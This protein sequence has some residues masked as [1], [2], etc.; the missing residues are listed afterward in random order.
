MLLIL[1]QE[2][3]RF[4]IHKRVMELRKEPAVFAWG[5]GKFQKREDS[6]VGL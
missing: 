5:Q 3:I 6:K 4:M 1:L 2:Y